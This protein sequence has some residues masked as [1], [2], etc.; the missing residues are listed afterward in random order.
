[1][2]C[3]TFM[4]K[5]L[6]DSALSPCKYVLARKIS[7]T[8]WPTHSSCRTQAERNPFWTWG[9]ILRW[10]W[11]YSFGASHSSPWSC[12]KLTPPSVSPVSAGS[13]WCQPASVSPA[14]P[15]W[16]PPVSQV[17]LSSSCVRLY[18]GVMRHSTLVPAEG[19]SWYISFRRRVC[20]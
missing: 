10:Q 2:S 9:G 13:P 3:G 7:V 1:M 18:C 16:F 15:L 19:T 14:P 11:T 12:F 5:E 20:A 17:I 8:S 6:I 4:I